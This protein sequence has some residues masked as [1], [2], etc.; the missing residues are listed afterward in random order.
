[1]KYAV[2][3]FFIGLIIIGLFLWITIVAAVNYGA[4]WRTF[5]GGLICFL[6]AY[7]IGTRCINQANKE[8]NKSLEKREE[9]KP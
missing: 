9:D 3:Y 7:A 1:M 8:L 6:A 2:I 5:M 4:N